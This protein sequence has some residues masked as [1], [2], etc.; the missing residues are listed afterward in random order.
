[1][2]Y[3][4]PPLCLVAGRHSRDGNDSGVA[5]L[6]QQCRRRGRNYHHGVE[7]NS[8]QRVCR[9]DENKKDRRKGATKRASGRKQLPGPGFHINIMRG[10]CAFLV[11]LRGWGGPRL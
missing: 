7:F 3:L 4:G 5:R 6:T 11:G 8:R 1:M 9:R 10:L 2:R